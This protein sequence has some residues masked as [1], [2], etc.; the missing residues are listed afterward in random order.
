M[1]ANVTNKFA[2]IGVTPARSLVETAHLLGEALG[3]I[4]FAED[5]ARRF[6]EFPSFIAV[7]DGL[8]Y[9]LLGVP[10]EEDD[11]RDERAEDFSLLVQPATHTLGGKNE[12]I[13]ERLV[14]R[15]LR[16]GRICCWVLK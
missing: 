6:D 2:E 13:S 5:K 12:D 10:A 8:Q 15:I 16:D 7:D 4:H 11:L 14:E 1:T 9:A 3:G